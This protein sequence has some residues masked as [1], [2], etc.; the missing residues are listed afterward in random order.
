MA[1]DAKMEMMEKFH[2]HK[3]CMMIV[4]GILVIL[5]AIYSIVDWALFVGIVFVLIG[6]VSKL[7][8]CKKK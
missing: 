5:N 7:M 1:K 8:M 6:L 2:K 3:S 4:V